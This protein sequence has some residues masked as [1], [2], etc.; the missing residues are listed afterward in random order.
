MRR[1]PSRILLKVSG[2]A[3]KSDDGVLSPEAFSR[4]AGE[5]AP[6]PLEIAI[7]VGGGNIL[8][9][10]HAPWLD[11]VEADSVG[12]LAT[13]LN[14]M[15]LRTALEAVGKTVVVQSAV[16]VEGLDP[17]SIREATAA[18]SRGDI[19]IFAGGTGSPFV[20]TD[21]AAAIRAVAIHADLLAKASNVRGV[22]DRDPVDDPAAQLIE[23]LTYE[24]FLENRY[25][26]MDQVSIEICREHD[27][28]IEV[29]SWDRPGA[30]A[31]LAS[32]SRVGTRISG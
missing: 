8:R 17:I 19:V 2:E 1:S 9:G 11:R 18:L 23:D 25:G 24:R 32:G 28:P 22:Y 12:M 15:V 10:A 30:L 26:V 27:L 21:T 13:A 31:D 20:S 14:A 4:V 3:F 6:L 16:H 7:V 5:I 29:F